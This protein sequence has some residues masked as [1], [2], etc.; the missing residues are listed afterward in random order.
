MLPGGGTP[1]EFLTAVQ[2]AEALGF[3]SAWV[4]DHVL[5]HVFWPEPIAMLSAA[6]LLLFWNGIW[7]KMF[8]LALMVANIMMQR[9]RPREFEAPEAEPAVIPVQADAQQE[10]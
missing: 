2:T 8:G 3:D 9:S 10:S 7:F 5:W 4:G 1:E 6:S